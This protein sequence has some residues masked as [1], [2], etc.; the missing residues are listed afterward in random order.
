MRV[1]L[2]QAR[3]DGALLLN[4]LMSKAGKQKRTDQY[5]LQAKIKSNP[6]ELGGEERASES[7]LTSA[8]DAGAFLGGAALAAT[9]SPLLSSGTRNA[10]GVS[11][12]AAASCRRPTSAGGAGFFSPGVVLGRR[13]PHEGISSRWTRRL[14]RRRWR[15]RTR[16]ARSR[17]MAATSCSSSVNASTT[18]PPLLAMAAAES[19]AR[20]E[21]RFLRER[22]ERERERERELSCGL[23]WFIARAPR[24]SGEGVGI[25]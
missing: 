1:F 16:S 3:D 15:A 6:I 5:C 2:R 9:S 25:R 14:R 24:G 13:H 21:E 23:V 11:G 4:P 12:L 8:C 19:A 17:R 10:S 22:G 18:T 20:A 7:D